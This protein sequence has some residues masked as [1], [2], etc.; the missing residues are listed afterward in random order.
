MHG[1]TCFNAEAQSGASRRNPNCRLQILDFRLK[2]K[3]C[4]AGGS[5]ETI[6]KPVGA[7]GSG[8]DPDW[9]ILRA[10]CRAPLPTKQEWGFRTASAGA[11][12]GGCNPSARRDSL[13]FPILQFQFEIA[14]LKSEISCFLC[15]SALKINLPTVGKCKLK[16]NQRCAKM[17]TTFYGTRKNSRARRSMQDTRSSAFHRSAIEVHLGR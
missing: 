17:L 15:A 11:T 8:P 2:W 16:F 6:R 9:E 7:H 12:N 13:N 10:H 3:I 1:L 5:P 4:S 14:N